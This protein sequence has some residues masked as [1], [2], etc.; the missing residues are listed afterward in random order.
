M[1]SPIAS[2]LPHIE[3]ETSPTPQWTVIWLHG[4]GADGNDFASIVPELGLKKDLAV[5]FLFPHAPSIPITCNNGFVM[6]GWYDIL[7]FDNINR[8]ADEAGILASREALRALITRENQRGIATSHIIL[9]GFSQGGAMAY[10]AGLTHPEKLAGIMALSTYLPAPK[11]I[12]SELNAAN[13]QT[14][15]FAAHGVQDPVVP[16]A[17]GEQALKYVAQGRPTEWHSYNMQH[18]VCLE[19]LQAIGKWLNSRFTADK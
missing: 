13:S 7:Y 14:A 18:S 16:Y 10:T 17:L 11:L 12:E 9:A 2:V 8:H 4:L 5:R 15:V 19:E 6:P 1:S 3:I